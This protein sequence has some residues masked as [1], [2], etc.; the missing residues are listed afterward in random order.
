VEPLEVSLA[1]SGYSII[2]NLTF[3]LG[4]W[5]TLKDLAIDPYVAFRSAY[6]QNRNGKVAR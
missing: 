1:L 2:N 4:D 3:H 5:E 6:I